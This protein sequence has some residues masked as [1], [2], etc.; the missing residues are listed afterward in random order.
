MNSTKL[1]I[2]L[3]VLKMLILRNLSWYSSHC[4]QGAQRRTGKEENLHFGPGSKHKNKDRKPVSLYV[5]AAFEERISLWSFK[6]SH[7]HSG[8]VGGRK[9]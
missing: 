9:I 2:R 6:V 8:K 7:S 5:S 3:W 1:R 4:K